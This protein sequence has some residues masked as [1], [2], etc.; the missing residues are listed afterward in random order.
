MGKK[1]LPQR[2]YMTD[3]ARSDAAAI[4]RRLPRGTGVIFRHYDAVDREA[5]AASLRALARQRHLVFLVAG[6][7]RLAARVKADGFHAPERLIHRI[8]AARRVLPPGLFTAAAHGPAGLIAARQ[9]GADGI[10]ISPVFATASHE[11]A[12][13]LG[14]VRFAALALASPCPVYALGGMNARRFQ[15]VRPSGARGYGAIGAFQN[16]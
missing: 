4:M 6:D 11:G 16:S 2:F 5:L 7:V 9:A 8:T 12:A 15:R 1:L 14:P 10:F 3:A 13:L